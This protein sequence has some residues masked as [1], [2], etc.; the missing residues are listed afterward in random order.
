MK[1][2]DSVQ[3]GSSELAENGRNQTAGRSGG[4][5]RG[6]NIRRQRGGGEGRGGERGEKGE[7]WGAKGGE[8]VGWGGYGSCCAGEIGGGG[9]EKMTG[10][11]GQI[12]GGTGAVRV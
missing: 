10:W 5:G 3:K 12:P 1:R 8:E 6:G 2:E 7:T 4:E 9:E 11:K